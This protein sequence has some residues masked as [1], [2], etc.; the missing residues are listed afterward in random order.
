MFDALPDL[1]APLV[2]ADPELRRRVFEAFQFGVELDRSKPKI[3][4]RA[5]VSSALR[6]GRR[7]ATSIRSRPRSPI[8]P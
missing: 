6:C 3:R 2:K 5:L 4:I 7:A 8:R 1:L